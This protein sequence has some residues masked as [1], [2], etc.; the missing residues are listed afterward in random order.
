MQINDRASE[1][2]IHH[3]ARALAACLALQ[4][5]TAEPSAEFCQTDDCQ[6]PIP[7]ARRRAVPGVQFCIRCQTGRE[8]R[9]RS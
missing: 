4:P 1:L 3:R 2:E 8:M 5:K 7:D 6:I 9:A